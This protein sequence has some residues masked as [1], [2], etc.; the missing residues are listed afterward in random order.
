MKKLSPELFDQRTE[1][2]DNGCLLWIG[3]RS[4][5]FSTGYGLWGRRQYAH[6][7]AY[8]RANGEI[9]RGLVVCHRCDTPLC[10]E[11]EH[12]FLGTR[13]DNQR[14]MATKGRWRN[15]YSKGGY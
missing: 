1:R 9:P 7:E 13:A 4:G 2:Q 11:P 12:L 5:T 14:D 3:P 15:Q 10:V 6:H 8:K